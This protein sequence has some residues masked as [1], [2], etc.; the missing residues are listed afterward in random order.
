M[1]KQTNE[2]RAS[3]KISSPLRPRIVRRYSSRVHPRVHSGAPTPP[4]A[5]RGPPVKQCERERERVRRGTRESRHPKERR[6]LRVS[7]SSLLRAVG[8][9]RQERPWTVPRHRCAVPCDNFRHLS[10][11]LP[12]PA[13]PVVRTSARSFPPG[14]VFPCARVCVYMCVRGGRAG[15]SR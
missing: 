11:T 7:L 10:A 1:S 5:R 9:I 12:P 6:V 4:G 15:L 14:S 3:S 2:A 8:G 13:L